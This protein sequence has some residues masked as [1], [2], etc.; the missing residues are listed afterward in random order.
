MVGG[1]SAAIRPD[2]IRELTKRPPVLHG[3]LVVIGL[4]LLEPKLRQ[5]L[6]SF[7]AFEALVKELREPLSEI[8]TERGRSLLPEPV[9]PPFEEPELSE[10]VPVWG[11][12]PLE[13][14]EDDL[15]GRAAFA[16]Y[17][18]S[19]I[20]AIPS[21]SGAYVMLL[22]GPWGAGKS[23]LLNFM[24]AELKNP[25]LI[26]DEEWLLVEFNAWRNQHIQPPWW[27]LMES[28]FQGTKDELSWGDQL[29]EYWWRFSTV[30]LPYLVGVVALAWILAL[31]VIPLL[32]EQTS[33]ASTLS[34]LATSAED[35]SK[36]LALIATI[37]GAILAIN[38]SFLL[39]SARAARSYT[40][41][42]HDPTGEIKKRF[43]ELVGRLKPKR[44]AVFIDDLDR[45]QSSYVVR[46]LEGIQTLFR[47][48]P[49]VFVVVA[50]RSWLNA[51]YEQVYEKLK[52][53]VFEPGKPLGTL[54]L[55]KA[56]RFSAPMPGIPEELKQ[57]YWLYLLQVEPAERKADL[58]SA[59]DRAREE[60]S[61]AKERG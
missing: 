59:K 52:P 61:K 18:V 15:L 24:R 39:S 3:R 49:V 26:K 20:A 37:W 41:L 11:D 7:G 47:E 45:C 55:E 16:R 1:D 34:Y 9:K 10:S 42:T 14:L 27:S 46:L 58:D 54:F 44:V 50:D 13:R 51:C 38:R 29:R 33:E 12:D 25:D 21:D 35:I 6:E 23:T 40:E 43:E 8:L 48:A 17:Q 28:V 60:I 53:R 36:I 22:Y 30:R 32:R 2:R 56:F 57:R 19:R 5:Q 4:S 31:I